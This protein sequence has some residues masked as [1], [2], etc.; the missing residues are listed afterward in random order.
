MRILCCILAALAAPVRAAPPPEMPEAF[1][2]DPAQVVAAAACATAA[3]F[4]DAD[5]VVVDDRL[6]TRFEADGS[7]IV[8]DD[9][10][11]KV[12]TEKGRRAHATVSLDYS[13]RYG[14]AGIL[15]V[16]IVGTNGVVRPVDFART[17]KTATDNAS[18][19]SNIV[20]PLDRTLSCAV[21]GLAVGEVRHVRVWRRTRKARMRGA[22]ADTTLLEQT[23]PIL[24]TVVTVD[25]PAGLP[26]VHAAVRRPCADTVARA[27]DR[28]LAD[29]RRLLAWTARDVP[30]AFTEPNMP[31]LSRAVQTLR[32]STI[33]GWPTVSRWY[34]NLC[35]PHLARTTPAMTNA[36]RT[37]T[38]SCRTEDERIRALFRFVSQEVRYMGLTLEDDAPGYE[39]HDVALTFENRYGVCRDKAALLVALLRLAGVEAYPVL[40][41]AGAKMD[42]EI[43]SP[44]FNH[45]VVAVARPASG[46]LLMD[47]TDESTKDLLPA[48]LSDKSYL[49]ARPGGERLLTSPVPS[50]RANTLRVDSSGTLD[51]DG[52]ILLT[53]SFA[54]D[55]INDTVLRHTLLRKTPAARRRWFEGIWRS[56]VAGADLLSLEVRPQD[57]CDTEAPLA[58]TT[59]TYLPGALL[60]GRTR[61]A[62]TLPFATAALSVVEGLLDEN[63]ALETRRFPLVLPCTA[64]TEETLR[65]TLDAS[66]GAAQTL[67][68]PADVRAGTFAYARTV[69]CTNGVLSARRT[70]QVADVEISVA[71]YDALRAARKDVE[72]AERETALFAA[73]DDAGAHL[74]VREK[75]TVAHL[76]APTAWVT[77]NTVE[78]ETLTPRGKT[79]ASE[80]TFAYTPC[81]RQVELVSATVSNR[82]GQVFAVTPKEVNLLDGDG[83]ASAP[84]YPASK[85]LVV[86]L[87]GVEVGSVIRTVVV[88]TV[89]NAPIAYNGRHVFGGRDPVDV[90][91]VELHV[92]P[93]L[94]LRLAARRMPAGA[95]VVVTNGGVRV[96]SWTLRQPPRT[97]D[98][99]SQPPA[100]L[101]R[102]CV[103]VSLADWDAYGTALV[104]ALAAARGEGAAAARAAARARVRDCPTPAARITALRTA[105]RTV[106]T[107]GPGLF[108]LPLDRAFTAPDRVYAEGYGSRADRMNLLYTM[109]EAAGFDCSFVLVADDARGFRGTEAGWR[110]VP[111]P[112]IFDTLAVRAVWR[113]GWLPFFRD[114][115]VFWVSAENEYTPPEASVRFGASFFDPQ[116]NAFG[117]I[118]PADAAWAAR[119]DNVCRMEVRANGAVDFDITNRTYGAR[120]GA[121]RKNFVELLPELRTRFH[122]KLLGALAQN[123]TATG[124]LETD[125]EGYPFALAFRAYAEGFAVAKDDA[126]TVTIPDFTERLFAVGGEERR[127]P[128]AVNGKGEVVDTYEIVFPE[129]YG[130]V[131]RLPEA[132][133][134]ANPH[135]A[136]DVWLRQTVASKVVDGRLH[137]TVRRRVGRAKAERFDAAY[138]PFFREW[139]RRAAAL[140]ARAVTARRTQSIREQRAGARTC[141]EEGW[142]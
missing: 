102:P 117:R 122:Q 36:V 6:H 110:A 69:S 63:T 129:G 8:W 133:T 51:A 104:A 15:A 45:A 75:T 25:A 62:L 71:A 124:E 114:E 32:L 118:E 84:R 65:L 142:K 99:P 82:N 138:A 22:W 96:F 31:P 107:A 74:R 79:S 103:S 94:E 92:P 109:L 100:A 46:Y 29:G 90:E 41:H 55:G 98:E 59:C 37:L 128:L 131:E 135:D 50:V 39:P 112:G 115:T 89:T 17:L 121:L 10:W 111:R 11:I 140:G 61:D 58:A 67:P 19:D 28:P 35:A 125:T 91:R 127:S 33:P 123:A 64:G 47:P 126:L 43:P 5:S 137:V 38:Q 20:D 81:T 54:F 49:V 105:L 95:S 27:P 139:N 48:Y 72:T 86:N 21:P 56:V 88:T 80:L 12:L 93:G 97:P 18:L 116:R 26:L 42:P 14:D 23:A 68:A 83:A 53:T 73:R 60:R 7:D 134:L 141:T 85:I 101:W 40:I 30:Q 13:A 1:R 24:S 9:E 78:K 16:E 130:E 52:G 136:A 108:E 113:S 119:E 57:L 3:R 120:V 132:L 76:A 34:W 106:R 77:T 2:A 66:L 4:P 87:P 70:M 44:Y